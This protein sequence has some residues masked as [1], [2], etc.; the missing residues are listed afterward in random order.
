MKMTSTL[1]KL[2][3]TVA[4]VVVSGC[5]ASPVPADDVGCFAARNAVFL[6][7]RRLLRGE[8]PYCDEGG[9]WKNVQCGIDSCY[10][11]YVDT[12]VQIQNLNLRTLYYSYDQLMGMCPVRFEAN[13]N[14]ACRVPHLN[15][16]CNTS[17]AKYIYNQESGE[18]E[19]TTA[20]RCY[21]FMSFSECQSSCAPVVHDRCSHPYD[22]GHSCSD[23]TPT[24][25]YFHNPSM[26]RCELFYYVGCGGNTN[27]YR[28]LIECERTCLPQPIVT[29]TVQV[30]GRNTYSLEVPS[31]VL[32]DYNLVADDV[33]QISQVIMDRVR[34][35]ARNQTLVETYVEATTA[36]DEGR[37]LEIGRPLPPIEAKSPEE[38]IRQVLGPEVV[39]FQPDQTGPCRAL[40][41][42]WHFNSER[43]VCERL[44]YGG[45]D[46]NGNNFLEEQDCFEY[47]RAYALPI[48][49]YV[50]LRSH[51]SEPQADVD[52]QVVYRLPEVPTTTP[53]ETTPSPTIGV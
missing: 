39:C 32:D 53:E 35:V 25:R 31:W 42:R 36:T 37:L 30:E 14:D 23:N 33:N 8:W 6:D 13:R 44:V 10:C 7:I 48:A 3:V 52:G 1:L 11:A 27:N 21:G 29:V 43:G 51:N 26:N 17:A 9:L 18:C 47:C 46:P 4:V 22:I 40:F 12:G 41:R 45:C 34:L 19:E 15:Y 20:S 50:E 24:G 16:P 38:Q 28:T 5:M 49:S 2:A